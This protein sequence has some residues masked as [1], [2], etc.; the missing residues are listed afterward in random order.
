MGTIPPVIGGEPL[1]KRTNHILFP[2]S[3]TPYNTFYQNIKCAQTSDSIK[4]LYF[5]TL[6][7]MLDRPNITLEQAFEECL[8]DREIELENSIIATLL[9]N[10][11]DLDWFVR[12]YYRYQTVNKLAR[13]GY[14]LQLIGQGWD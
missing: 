10:A 12:M 2:G 4:I 5:E 9:F 14:P 1:E 6:E 11:K 3:Y 13:E 7:R 8:L